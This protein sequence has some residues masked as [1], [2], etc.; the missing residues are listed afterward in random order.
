MTTAFELV[1]LRPRLL[2]FHVAAGLGGWLGFT[3]IGVSYRLLPM[4]LLSPEAHKS[5][6]GAVWGCGSAALLLLAVIAPLALVFEAGTDVVVALAVVLA[7]TALAFYAADLLFFFRHRRRK[8][9]ELNSTAAGVAFAMLFLSA[10]LAAALL[11]TGLLA[12]HAGALLYFVAFGWLTGLGLS[13]LYKIVPFLTWLECYGPV[14][15]RKPTPRVQDLVVEQRGKVW[16]ALYFAS[17]LAGTG[18]LLMNW[19]SL[20]RVAATGSLAATVAIVG[21]LV[22]AR[23]LFNVAA[24]RRLPAGVSRPRL[25]LPP[26]RH[27]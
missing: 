3:A 20:F 6:A 12:R 18:A 8:N 27:G 7:A 13:Q 2:P 16:F 9:I 15:G 23:L 25:F 17:V 19:D 26:L 10:L 5:T 21:E 1:A 22:L 4:F 14:M 11:A 24:E